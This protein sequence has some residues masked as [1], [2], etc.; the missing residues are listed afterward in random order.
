MKSLALSVILTLALCLATS[1]PALAQT[2][3]ATEIYQSGDTVCKGVLLLPAGVDKNT[4]PTDGARPAVLLCHAWMGIGNNEL[5]WA[6]RL[7]EQG[8]VVLCADIYG[9]G[10]KPAGADEARAL[11]T[12]FKNDR[13]LLRERANAGLAA[14]K[15]MRCVDPDQVAAIGFCFG[16]TTVLELARSGAELDAVVSIHGGLDSP[17]PADGAN[18][19]AKVLVLH[20]A[21]DPFV[22]ADSITAFQKEMRDN[23]IDWEMVYYGGAVH[24]FT[25]EEAGSDNS[26]GAAY[27]AEAAAKSWD[28]MLAFF[29]RVVTSN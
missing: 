1:L 7:A 19:K 17:T 6:K 20:G 23:K 27:N 4:A 15:A 5:S 2:N 12:Q 21:D 10:T 26:K 13:A 14:L 3:M 24:A 29:D 22:P 25:E 28:A 16:G 8:Y 9:K 18:I 11:T